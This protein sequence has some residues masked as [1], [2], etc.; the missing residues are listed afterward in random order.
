[1]AIVSTTD[2]D[3]TVPEHISKSE[4]LFLSTFNVPTYLKQ[5]SLEDSTSDGAVTV[6]SQSECNAGGGAVV[7]GTISVNF[8]S[9]G[10]SGET[11][12]FFQTTDVQD[13]NE[14]VSSCPPVGL[15]EDGATLEKIVDP[16]T[17][18]ERLVL[19]TYGEF[20][21]GTIDDATITSEVGEDGHTYYTVTESD[22][23]FFEHI[24]E[25][26]SPGIIKKRT[27]TTTTPNADDMFTLMPSAV[28]MSTLSA[29]ELD[30]LLNEVELQL[31]QCEEVYGTAD[32]KCASQQILI[33]SVTNAFSAAQSKENKEA[34][35]GSLPIIIAI[36]A[37]IILVGLVAVFMVLRKKKGNNKDVPNVSFENPMSVRERK[38]SLYLSQQIRFHHGH[39]LQLNANSIPYPASCVL[40]LTFTVAQQ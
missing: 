21:Q 20:N 1:M 2:G 9:C 26:D 10:S 13:P 16:D 35:T 6:F 3:F 17:E 32:N 19:I 39:V 5:L 14:C 15:F 11:T 22:G 29:A 27:T 31:E 8:G 23:T 34:G 36:A 4:P 37:V 25:N 30:E 7:A 33:A 40:P 18:E 12:T 24:M 38:I 28:D